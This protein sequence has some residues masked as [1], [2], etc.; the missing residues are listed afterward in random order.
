M[1]NNLAL[2]RRLGC[3]S[4]VLLFSTEEH[5]LTASDNGQLAQYCDGFIH[6]GCRKP[7]TSFSISSLIAHKLDF[8]I[9]GALGLRGRR[10]PFSMRYDAIGAERIIITEAL[11]TEADFVVLPSFM[12]HYAKALADKG[13]KV[14][15]DAIDVLTD[16][17]S[18]LLVN[19]GGKGRASKL[20]L[21]ANHL[22]SRS[23]E[24]LY[25]PACVEIWATTEAE[26]VTLRRISRGV[27]S[28]VVGNCMDEDAV[29]PSPQTESHS[30]GFIGTY[31]MLPNVEAAL[32]LAEK[33]FPH[34]LK[35]RPQARLR[36]AG[37]HMPSDAA[38]RL[39]SFK[40]VELLGAVPDSKA[41]F[42]SCA[43]IALPIFVYGG[44][45]LKLVE[46]MARGKAVV[47]NTLL[48]ARAPVSDGQDLIIRD[49]PNAFA[50]AIVKLLKDPAERAR[51][52]GNARNTFLKVWS[53]K[54]AE[55]LL[56]QQSILARPLT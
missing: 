47:V 42:D 35:H 56:R 45:P 11:R 23:Q 48:G 9:G 28:V 38:A 10:Y 30:V 31:S 16:L 36:L 33:V 15:A 34:V 41:F 53:R 37:A 18:S 27:N 3:E 26:A 40:H 14:I 12:L 2:L 51:L 19:Y 50:A 22:A 32:F 17:T 5:A 29:T 4:R 49:E 46:A 39:S 55:V 21:L 8:L 43:V 7:Q 52:G 1:V 25:L 44:T 24:R 54:Q 20:G 13:F 6:G